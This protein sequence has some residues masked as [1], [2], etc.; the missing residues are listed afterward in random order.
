MPSVVAD[1]SA[2]TPASFLVIFGAF[3]QLY[4]LVIGGQ[5]FPLDIFP[6][7]TERSSFFDGV[8]GNYAPSVAEFALGFGGAGLALM[9][10]LI[11]IKVLPFLPRK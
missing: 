2:V 7:Y 3:C 6:G 11:G 5:A 4:V 10:I 9:I 1:F 8:V